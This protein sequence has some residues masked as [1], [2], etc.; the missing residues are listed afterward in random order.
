VDDKLRSLADTEIS[1]V[2]PLLQYVTDA[3]GKRV[4]PAITLLAAQFHPHDPARPIFMA[5]AVE[6]LHLATL[7]HDDTVDNSPLRR[8]RATVSNTWT[9]HVA[10]LFGDYVFATSATFVCDTQNIRVIRRFS[11]TIMELASGQ[12]MEF[13]T[14][15]DAAQ[16]RELY[17]DRIYR[18]TA[19]LF[20]T[21]SESGAVLGEAPED[22]IQALR[23]YGYNLGMA[24]QVSDDLLDF[25]GDAS[26]LGKPVGSDLLNG[27]LT[28]PT[29]ML[30]ERYP[31]DDLVQSL[32]QD[33]TNDGKLE[34][35]VEVINDSTILPDCE[36]VV[37]DY[38][39][40]ACQALRFLPD[41]DPKRSLLDLADYL[42]SRRH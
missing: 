22:E 32:F 23:D 40:K 35:V 18:K 5:S 37:Q 3:G 20:C 1:P 15:F 34:K 39:D 36:R 19:S 14:A 21:A 30:M 28:L 13:F 2:Q 38:S 12:I 25:Q 9:P 33:P 29:I 7:I 6:L 26:N 11:E 24:F 27:V 10:V 8:G 42:I 17:N 31:N 16:A 4:R 41:C